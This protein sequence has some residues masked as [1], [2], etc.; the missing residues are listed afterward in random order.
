T[1]SKRKKHVAKGGSKTKGASLGEGLTVRSMNSWLEKISP[2]DIARSW[3][4]LRD[5]AKDVKGP[6]MSVR[7]VSGTM[8]R[9][10][11]AVGVTACTMPDGFVLR[12][13]VADMSTSNGASDDLA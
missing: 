4:G 8:F 1:T 7:W 13:T 3:N 12:F 9:E 5:S 10:A 2:L 6:I 11:L